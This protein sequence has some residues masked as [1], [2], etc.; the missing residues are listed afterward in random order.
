MSVIDAKIKTL[1]T[2]LGTVI[3]PRT[4]LKAV[5]ATG[6]KGQ[7]VGFIEDNILGPMD[8]A[9]SIIVDPTPEKDSDNAVSSGGVYNS[10][11]GL[12]RAEP[13]EE[14]NLLPIDADTLDGKH[15]DEF[16]SLV[17]GIIPDS[18][19]PMDSTAEEIDAAVQKIS[20]ILSGKGFQLQN[21]SPSTPSTEND[22]D[23]LLRD[24]FSKMSNHS[25][26]TF[27]T[28][29]GTGVPGFSGGGAWTITIF[30]Y[31]EQ[32]G[33]VEVKRYDASGL[34]YKVRS[35]RSGEWTN[36]KTISD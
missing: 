28:Q 31:I 14:A 34:I 10:L 25:V 13:V 21:P 2:I 18:E 16:A 27:Y 29:I 7:T 30:R 4:V 32:Y 24:V 11:T 26:Y 3:A 1:K 9:G 6:K 19:L 17:N 8:T 12:L 23:T 33:Y 35:L 20:S 15:A 5:S 36:W 22:L